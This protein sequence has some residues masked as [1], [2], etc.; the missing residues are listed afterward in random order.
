[1]QGPIAMLVLVG[2]SVEVICIASSSSD[3]DAVDT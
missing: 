1:M 3:G 2:A